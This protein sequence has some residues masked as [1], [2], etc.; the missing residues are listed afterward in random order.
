MS[1][2]P[3]YKQ[4]DGLGLAELVRSG[5]VSAVEV[6]EEAIRRIETYNPKINAVIHKMYDR[7]RKAAQGSLPDGPFKGVPFLYKDLH[8][9]LEGVPTSC[10]G[11]L[12][13][14][15]PQTHDSETAIR[16][17]ASGIN[18]LGKTNT[19]EL[20]IFPYT[21]PKTFGP[22]NNPWDLARSPGGSS[23]GSAAAV[24]ARL[25][26]LAGAADGGGSIRIPAS[27]C[28]VFGLKPTRGR[29]PMGP[30]VGEFWRGFAIEHVISISVRDSAAMLDCISGPDVGTPYWAP[31][32][33]RPYLKEV[34]TEPSKLR[35][36]FT[37]F[38]FLGHE[39][40]PDCKKGL[41]ATVQLLEG[42][43]HQLVEAKPDF[44][45]E[46]YALAF[47]TMVAAETRAEIEWAASLVGRKASPSDFETMTYIT[48]LIGKSVTAAD[49][50]TALNYMQS[51]SRQIGRF[52][53]KVDILLTPTVAQPPVLTGSL[54]PAG[55]DFLMARLCSRLEAVWLLKLMGVVKSTAAKTFDFMP[56]TPLANVTGQP[57]MSVPVYWNEAGLPVGM[58]FTGR[59]GDETTLFRLAGQLER[60]QPWFQ[61]IPPGYE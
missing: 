15:V 7:A 49:Y 52:F 55:F 16:Y 54:M 28:G 31:P 4:Y 23:G 34:E 21:E 39:V 36:A 33:Q 26:P 37:D 9:M 3:E 53:E 24:A 27:C 19:P 20:G 47:L 11:S 41:K 43:G 35:I 14:D 61:R 17:K 42:L 48:G 29:T 46:A 51:V 60:A 25:V 40:H 56:Y 10:G 5:Q 50:A 38:P 44:D 22:T 12:L 18:S 6:V 13:K 58:M 2:F 59:F 30:D 45:G 8:T 57:S 32:Q 1:A